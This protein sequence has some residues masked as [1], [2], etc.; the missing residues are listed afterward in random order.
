[1]A[2]TDLREWIA[3][4]E[5]AKRLKRIKAEVNWDGEIGAIARLN[6]AKKGPALLFENIKDHK[7]TISKK[8]FVGGLARASQIALML[9]LPI[10]TNYEKIVEI[11]RE[12]FKKKILPNMLE[13]GF[14]KEN[15]LLGDKINLFEFPVPKWH[16]RDGGRYINTFSAIV[17]R[18]PETGILNV[19]M[20]R[21]MILDRERIGVLLVPSQHWGLHYQKYRAKGMH[22]PVAVVIGWDP[23]LSFVAATPL[24]KDVCEYDIAGSLREKAV[25]LVKCETSDLLVPATSEIVIEGAI[26]PDPKDFEEEGPFGEYTGYYGERLK[27]PVIKVSCITHRNNPIF[28]GTLEGINPSW[29]N[30]S[31]T[32][33]GIHLAAVTWNILESQGVPGILDL[34]PAPITIVKIHKTFQGHPKQVASALWGSSAAQYNYKIVI[35]VDDDVNIRDYREIYTALSYRVNAAEEDIVIMKESFGS[36]LDPSTPFENRDELKYGSGLWDRILIDATKS[37]KHPNPLWSGEIYPPSSTELDKKDL[38]L[39]NKR[40]EEYGLE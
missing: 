35:V 16:P 1:V 7:N 2:Y 17:T 30:E 9:G 8:L 29:P 33:G 6:F 22:M 14:V 39:V 34:I 19:G 15:V 12:R 24:P 27:R 32:I 38:E 4:L 26:S 5:S 40:W 25:D 23:A 18:D 21:G 28:R 36:A 37:F 13:N 11:V 20:Y 10:D 3:R 31:S